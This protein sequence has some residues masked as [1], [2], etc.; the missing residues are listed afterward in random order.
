MRRL[1][2]RDNPQKTIVDLNAIAEQAIQLLK[3]DSRVLNFNI[4]L[5]RG[6]IPRVPADRVQIAQVLV[7][8]LRNSLDAICGTND[9]VIDNDRIVIT[10][11][12]VDNM[13]KVDVSDTGPGIPPGVSLFQSFG[14]TKDD[15]LCLLYTS[16]SPRDL[17]TSRMPSSA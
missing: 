2:R 9:S 11:L 14:T 3:R 13:V 8:L 16:P 6:D 17:S 12:E 1:I 10:T 15:G 5:N 7:N 4:E